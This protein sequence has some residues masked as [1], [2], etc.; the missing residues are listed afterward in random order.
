MTRRSPISR[1]RGLEARRARPTRRRRSTILAAAFAAGATARGAGT[2]V[3][4]EDDLSERPSLDNAF[5]S[6]IQVA[7]DLAIFPPIRV[8]ISTPDEPAAP[9]PIEPISYDV[10]LVLSNGALREEPGH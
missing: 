8:R 1:R 5:S 6:G 10:R 3:L 2:S 4:L 7:A 9:G